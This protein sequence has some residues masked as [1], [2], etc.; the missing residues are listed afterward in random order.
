MALLKTFC[1]WYNLRYPTCVLKTSTAHLAY[2][3]LLTLFSFQR[4]PVHLEPL[5]FIY[6]ISFFIMCQT[7]FSLAIARHNLH[8][9]FL[10]NIMTA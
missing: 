9:T 6:N 4:T 8:S 3:N 1:C 5:T 2:F 7:L 10:Y